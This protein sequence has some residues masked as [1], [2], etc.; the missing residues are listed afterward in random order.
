MDTPFDFGPEGKGRI[1][2]I[3]TIEVADLPQELQA[4]AGGLKH[5][6]AVCT[7]EGEQ[8]ALV[9]DRNLAFVLAR[10]ND[11]APVTVH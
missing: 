8:L 1:V 4:Q 7:P 6:Y 2:Y 3:K 9:H 11:L 10:Q 5:L